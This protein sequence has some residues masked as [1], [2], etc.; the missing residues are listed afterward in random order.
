MCLQRD[1]SR[2]LRLDDV[3][4]S[5]S[6]LLPFYDHDTHIL[7][8]AGKVSP[9][10]AF[11]ALFTLE[12][13]RRFTD[14]LPC[15]YVQPILHWYSIKSSVRAIIHSLLTNVLIHGLSRLA[16]FV[17]WC[18]LVFAGQAAEDW[19]PALLSLL[20]PRSWKTVSQEVDAQIVRSK[21]VDRQSRIRLVLSESYQR[22]TV[23][24]WF[25]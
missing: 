1:L 21:L 23:V 14:Y 22:R 15:T 8:L 5:S 20:Y 18:R 9:I 7:Y 13:C 4:A 10:N 24:V 6:V 17:F 12:T 3:D 11:R 25:F 19:V 2:P 16:T